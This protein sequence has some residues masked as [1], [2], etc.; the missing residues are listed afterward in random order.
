MMAVAL[1]AALGLS[2][3]VLT[4]VEMRVAAKLL[5]CPRNDG[6]AEA[7]LELAARELLTITDWSGCG[8]GRV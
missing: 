3:S 5:A 7:A 8:V 2:L 6:A 4:S 1:L